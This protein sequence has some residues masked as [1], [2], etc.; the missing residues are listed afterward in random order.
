MAMPRRLI[1]NE[2]SAAD[3]RLLVTAGIKLDDGSELKIRRALLGKQLELVSGNADQFEK[4]KSSLSSGQFMLSR[5]ELLK[6][7]VGV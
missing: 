5:R 3:T 7:M 4:L 6:Y 1:T 2:P